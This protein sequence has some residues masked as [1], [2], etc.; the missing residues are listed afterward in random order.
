MLTVLFP[1]ETTFWVVFQR[2]DSKGHNTYLRIYIFFHQ[3]VKQYLQGLYSFQAPWNYRNKDIIRATSCDMEAH[4]VI[5]LPQYWEVLVITGN[6]NDCQNKDKTH[7]W[8]THY[9]DHFM[10]NVSLTPF[11]LQIT[12]RESEAMKI[13][14]SNQLREIIWGA[15]FSVP[16]TK[17]GNFQVSIE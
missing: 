7:L 15:V 6:I 5:F 13:Q 12:K 11:Q 1:P 3:G 17:T 2:E 9:H 14:R 10:N 4:V 8:H 16:E